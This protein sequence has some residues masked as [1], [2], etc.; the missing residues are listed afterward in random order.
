MNFLRTHQDTS[1]TRI[2]L[3]LFQGGH[4]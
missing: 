4:D 3:T 2:Q 1:H